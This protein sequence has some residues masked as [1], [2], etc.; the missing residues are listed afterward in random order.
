M[1]RKAIKAITPYIPAST[2]LPEITVKAVILSALL[3]IVMAGSNAY[4][5]LKV[6]ISV[7][8]CIPAA[9]ISMAVL[10]LFGKSNILEN[11]VVQTAASAGE[12]IAAS[13]AFSLP[14]MVMIGYWDGFPYPIMISLTVVGGLLGVF[15]SV[16]LR[17]AMIIESD[18]K[19]PEG[20]ATAEVLKAGGDTTAAKEI[21][22]AG[23]AAAT[24]KF[25][26]SGFQF[27]ADSINIWGRAGSTVVGVS[28]G[29]SLALVGA[30]YIVGL[31]IAFAIFAGA[32][33]AWF[34]GVPLF[35]LFYGLPLDAGNAYTAAVEIWNSKIRIVGV[36]MMIFGALWMIV[37]LIDPL[38]RAIKASLEAVQ[39]IKT[40]GKS[41]VVRTEF[42][43]PITYVAFGVALLILPIYMIFN[44]IIVA[45]GLSLSFTFVIMTSLLIT[46]LVFFLSALGSAMS[47]YMC[48]ILGTSSSPISGMILMVILIASSALLVFF[49]LQ[50]HFWEDANAT[51]SVAGIT[52]LLGALI[53]CA[54][55]VAGDN[56][57]DLKSG[58]LVGST[59]WKQQVMLILGVL[60][61][62]VVLAPIFQLL[63][64]AYGFGEVLP[65]EGMDPAQALSAPKAALMAAVAQA[66]FNQS[67]DWS[68]IIA[69]ISL[70]I[71]V[72]L[73]DRA[74][75]KAESK[76]RFSIFAVAVGIYMPLDVTVPLLVGGILATL[77][78]KILQKS[79]A[80]ASEK[81]TVK[82]RGLL[83]ASGLIAGEAI[84][85][86]LIA[87]PFVAYQSTSVFKAV[88][89]ALAESTDVLG[90]IVFLT[91]L[92]W[93]H[94][95]SSKVKK[96]S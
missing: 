26:Q 63:F 45:S 52:I 4:L 34:I 95:V 11:N 76:W 90:L 82:R 53:G 87:I 80:N 78:Q 71:V 2:R 68:M 64:E 66:I 74:L 27:L 69:G 88:P 77:S 30:G 6:G 58:Q 19:F 5:V 3:A 55:G 75:K 15:L 23:C 81:E 21:V 18:L 49:S 35:G 20:V 41:N 57:Q 47:S 73:I 44:H 16:P 12:V 7:S 13:L 62:S 85:G 91:I 1:S 94:K 9:V 42:D 31:Q 40:E 61:S 89:A 43:I 93:F 51:L 28:A 32:I 65:R 37:E 48:G 33:L 56:M 29:F 46:I 14:A 59:P 24:I 84:V 17:R 54:V 10:K 8:A 36:G 67:M 72:L 25:C 50:P 39:K 22:F 96:E 60:V 92:Y 79:K 70:G 83:F 38:R 86:I